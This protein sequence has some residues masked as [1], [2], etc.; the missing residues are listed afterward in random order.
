[1]FFKFFNVF[2]FILMGLKEDNKP[3]L[4]THSKHSFRLSLMSLACHS[5]L[6]LVIDCL[7]S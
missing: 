2:E 7:Q 1:M 6:K 5:H 4:G 3:I